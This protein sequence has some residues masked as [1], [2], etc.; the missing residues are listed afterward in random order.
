MATSTRDLTIIVLLSLF[1]TWAFWRWFWCRYAKPSTRS[2]AAWASFVAFVFSCFPAIIVLN[3]LVTGTVPC[4]ARR[5]GSV[6]YSVVSEPFSYWLRVSI[7]A[8]I[9]LFFLSGALFG[10]SKSL[11]GRRG[12][13]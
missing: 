12:A 11:G 7:L 10:L 1:A 9:G 5:C 2:A 13:P 6:M 8:L 4:L 3:A